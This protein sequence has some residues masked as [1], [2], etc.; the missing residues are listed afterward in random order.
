MSG[1]ALFGKYRLLAELGHGGMADV[2]LAVAAGPGGFSK[3][4]VLKRLRRALV[5]DP[6][7]IAM[8][9]DEA[10]IAARLN[11]P[12]VIQANEVGHEGDEYY[13]AMEY[14]DGQPLSK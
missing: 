14:L 6:E 11:H 10:R 4:T 1:D 12:N 8:L 5:E 2:F 9:M 13:I 3:L 7:F